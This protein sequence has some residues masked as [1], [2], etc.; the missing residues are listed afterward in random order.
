MAFVAPHAP[1]FAAGQ[2]HAGKFARLSPLVSA[3]SKR[4]IGT[5]SVP[6]ALH[7]WLDF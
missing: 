2:D 5:Y 3:K 6:M 1:A 7:I 4:A